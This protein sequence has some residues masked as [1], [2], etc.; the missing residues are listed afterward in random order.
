[1]VTSAEPAGSAAAS[2]R[3]SRRLSLA[4]AACL[5]AALPVTLLG[6]AAT[7]GWP[8]LK[9]LDQDVADSLHS[10]ALRTPGAVR[11]LEGVSRVFDPWTLRVAAVAGVAV[12]IVR[13][14]R[15]LALWVAGVILGAGVLGFLLKELV[16]RA[17]PALP[18]AVA[19]AP[20]FSF[21]SGHALNSM[22]VAGVVVL[23]ASS[24]FSRGWR[25]VTW[26]AALAVVLLV[27]FSRIGLGVHYLSDVVAGWLVGVGW[28][29]CAAVAFEAWRRSSGLPARAP[30][31]V[32]EEGLEPVSE[33]Q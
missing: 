18:D 8:P 13:R 15:A 6:Y 31:E 20:G 17:R 12:L 30:S 24:R 21:P 11:F 5:A 28:L 4:G 29:A 2:A 32:V 16:R 3:L 14:Q 19:T 10:W 26:G 9:G 33:T 23:V 7:H 1:M 25:L 27:G 22:V